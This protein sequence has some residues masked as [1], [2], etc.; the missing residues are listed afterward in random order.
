MNEPTEAGTNLAKLATGFAVL[1][2]LSIGLCAANAALFSH[3]GAISGAS[4]K[5]PRSAGL[6]FVLMATGGIEL[7]GML[8]GAGGLIVVIVWAIG[9]AFINAWKERD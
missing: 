9:R 6:S 7:L 1:L 5:A 4:P 8:I 2:L 3:F